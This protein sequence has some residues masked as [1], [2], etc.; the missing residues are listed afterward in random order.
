VPALNRILPELAVGDLD[1]YV[2]AVVME[3]EIR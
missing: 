2:S 3:V 1:A